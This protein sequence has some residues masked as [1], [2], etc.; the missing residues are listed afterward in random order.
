MIELDAAI[1][2]GLLAVSAVAI[3]SAVV[4]PSSS[5]A[6]PPSASRPW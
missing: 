6:G 2:A 4:V 5:E 1:A 3:A